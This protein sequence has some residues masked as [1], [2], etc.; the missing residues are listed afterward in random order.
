MSRTTDKQQWVIGNGSWGMLV[1]AAIGRV[2]DG[3]GGFLEAPFDFVGPLSLDELE[4]RGRV[5]FGACLI[6]S[7]QRWR[8][9]QAD[10]RRAAQEQRRAQAKRLSSL[11][12]RAAGDEPRYRDIL[13]LPRVGTLEPSEIKA[14]F[15]RLAKTTHPDGGGSSEQ[16]RRITEARDVLLE[17][18]REA[19]P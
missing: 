16:F 13:D 5:A 17:H 14:A 4:T 18:A 15:R 12:Q 19:A 3:G 2:E 8:E 1:L 9:D 6:M 10:L 7:R 11:F